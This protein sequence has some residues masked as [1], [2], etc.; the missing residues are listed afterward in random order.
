MHVTELLLKGKIMV[1]LPT[2]LQSMNYF[3]SRQA[4]PKGEIDLGNGRV[5]G[6]E[7]VLEGHFRR[8]SSYRQPLN[9]PSGQSAT[10]QV[11]VKVGDNLMV[12]ITVLAPDLVPLT[13]IAERVSDAVPLVEPEPHF[14]QNLHQALERTHRQHAAQRVLGTRPAPRPKPSNLL[15]WWLVL[16]GGVAT[17]ALLWGLRGRQSAVPVV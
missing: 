11:A 7:D 14:R 1:A 3:W 9:Q 13:E 12:A 5:L 6:A 8:M 2:W 4:L 10:R 17:V 16:L 15:G